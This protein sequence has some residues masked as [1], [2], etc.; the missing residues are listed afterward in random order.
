MSKVYQQKNKID[1]VT[2]KRI[3][4]ALQKKYGTKEPILK[5][6]A[7][8]V[9]KEINPD[10]KKKFTAYINKFYG[11]KNKLTQAEL[12]QKSKPDLG[13]TIQDPK[14][15]TDFQ[16]V[17]RIF[18][19]Q[20]INKTLSIVAGSKIAEVYNKYADEIKDAGDPDT[21]NKFYEFL[22][23]QKE[24]SHFGNANAFIRYSKIRPDWI[25]IDAI[26]T[27]FFNNIKKFAKKNKLK[28]VWKKFISGILS[29]EEDT[30]KNAL[31][32]V[33]RQNPT[34]KVWTMNTPAM[35]DK[36][37]HIQ[38]S[39]K[40]NYF[41]KELPRKLGFKLIPTEKLKKTIGTRPKSKKSLEALDFESML[42]T[43]N[44]FLKDL[45]KIYPE[46]S[47]LK[48]E[49]V[50]YLKDG[51]K[52]IPEALLN[53]DLL[54]DTA[55]MMLKKILIK[56][57]EK[58]GIRKTARIMNFENEIPSVVRHVYK[59]DAKTPEKLADKIFKLLDEKIKWEKTK[60]SPYI[61][62]IWW[63]NRGMINEDVKIVN[64]LFESLKL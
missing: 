55:G 15:E 60:P 26:Q 52:N 14:K 13:G 62:E 49:L 54:E 7:I 21:M 64:S 27:D 42:F 56:A 5:D 36:A 28:G 12:Q 63:G 50:E 47:K 25:H 24:R 11:N 32:A 43:E 58:A 3:N 45:K 38:S 22:Q 57:R 37:E 33:K 8:K 46:A 2:L 51:W 30:Y 48:N 16:V 19:N 31:A 35:A 6:D 17:Q 4:R 20:E 18:P 61:D 23:M 53:K 44:R 40:N 39:S 29:T 59:E 10:E 41:Y 9:A 1:L 34:A